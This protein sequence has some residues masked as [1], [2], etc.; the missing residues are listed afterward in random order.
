MSKEEQ[1]TQES[2]AEVS[3]VLPLGTW[4]A[5]VLND[6]SV[7]LQHTTCVLDSNGDIYELNKG[8]NEEVM[9]KLEEKGS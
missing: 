6:G 4:C 3:K 1:Q 2:D 9:A 7:I 8:N 5:L